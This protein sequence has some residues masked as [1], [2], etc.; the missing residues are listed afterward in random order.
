MCAHCTFV[1]CADA[2]FQV[3]DMVLVRVGGGWQAFEDY[4]MKLVLY[5][6]HETRLEVRNLIRS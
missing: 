1:W 3:R 6:L 2:C 4:I 5:Q